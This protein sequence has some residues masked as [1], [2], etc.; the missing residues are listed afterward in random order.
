MPKKELVRL[1]LEK[2]EIIEDA[3]D[4]LEEQIEK[5]RLKRKSVDKGE[6]QEYLKETHEL[7]TKIFGIKCALED[8][9][10]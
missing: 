7:H 3:L 5:I 8:K 2:L 10:S 1:T 9:N 6:V 4:E